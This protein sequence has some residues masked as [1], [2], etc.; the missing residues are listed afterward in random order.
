MARLLHQPPALQG[1]ALPAAH[2]ACSRQLDQT[3]LA[4]IQSVEASKKGVQVWRWAFFFAGFVPIFWVSRLAV[5]L[6]VIVVEY[7]FFTSR[8]M[9]YLYGI[10]V[11]LLTLHWAPEGVRQGFEDADMRMLAT[12]CVMPLPVQPRASAAGAC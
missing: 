9:Y 4:R 6:L 12:S 5:H 1:N 3:A 10:R 11:R 7:A 8:V 2:R